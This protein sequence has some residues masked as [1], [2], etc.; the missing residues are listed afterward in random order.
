MIN[1]P[2]FYAR[3]RTTEL[4]KTLTQLQVDSIDALLSEVEA[5]GVT[6]MRQ[7]AYIMATAYHE[8]HRPSKPELRMTPMKEFGGETYLRGKK[9]YPYYGRGFSQLT[10]DYNYRKE[11]RRLGLDL[12]GNPDLILNIPV[13]ANSHVYCMIHGRYTGKKLADYITP[14]KADFINA[15]R[16]INGTDRAELVAGYA[17]KFVLCLC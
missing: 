15:R 6:D 7:V 4:F 11:G 1:R 13:A 17:E 16:I 10:W 5:Q 12:L 9:Y 14:V 3:L 2:E 8:C